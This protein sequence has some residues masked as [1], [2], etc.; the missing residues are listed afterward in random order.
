ML[1]LL[2]DLPGCDVDPR[3]TLPTHSSSVSAS[4]YRS[5]LRASSLLLSPIL[6]ALLPAK[7]SLLHW[8]SWT[9]LARLLLGADMDLL[10]GVELTL[11][12]PHA[13]GLLRPI[14]CSCIS[15]AGWPL[16]IRAV[17]AS[18]KASATCGW[19]RAGTL[20]IMPVSFCCGLLAPPHPS[21]LPVTFSSLCL[22]YIVGATS[23]TS[24]S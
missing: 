9:S 16:F 1:F 18:R 10:L 8:T 4:H 24:A 2:P 19:R 5:S 20:G 14:C 17:Y 6:V 13:W 11:L 23:S 22:L 12:G 15:L 3:L 21:I 7:G